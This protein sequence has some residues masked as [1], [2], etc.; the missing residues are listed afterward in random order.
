MGKY[1]K[2]GQPMRTDTPNTDWE[3]HDRPINVRKHRGVD[4]NFARHMERMR[5]KLKRQRNSLVS[6]VYDLSEMM[7]MEPVFKRIGYEEHMIGFKRKPSKRKYRK[8]EFML[9]YP[10]Y[11]Y[12]ISRD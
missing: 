9:E 11:F 1:V 3:Y 2:A 8:T 6:M 12:N 7:N 10:V 5:N 4:V